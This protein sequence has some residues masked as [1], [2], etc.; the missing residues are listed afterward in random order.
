LFTMEYHKCKNFTCLV[1][2]DDGIGSYVGPKISNEFYSWLGFIIKLKYY[3]NLNTA[4]FCGQ[5]FDVETRTVICDPIKVLLNFSWANIKYANAKV[6]VLRGL[7]RSK[8]LSLLHQYPGC[9][10]LQSFAQRMLEL[11]AC[12]KYVVDESDRWKARQVRDAVAAKPVARPVA[13]STR[14]LMFDVYG[15]TSIDQLLLEH[16]FENLESI[17]PLWHPVLN[18]YIK[19]VCFEYNSIYVSEGFGE[20]VIPQRSRGAISVSLSSLI[21]VIETKAKERSW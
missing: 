2:G 16:Y 4:S 13:M 5:I 3:T 9:P 14:Q 7:L 21:N 18:Y 10:I 17:K 11:T 8:A 20:N 15:I 6:K 12:Y 19:D 1:E